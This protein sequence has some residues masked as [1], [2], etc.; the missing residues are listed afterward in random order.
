M[1]SVILVE[2]HSIVSVGVQTI[3]DR[4][5]NFS[6]KEIFTTGQ[7]GLKQI[8]LLEPDIAI[9]DLNLPDLSGESIIKDLFLNKA[10]TKI[11]VLSWQKFLPQVN[12]LLSLGVS[13]YILKDNSANEI[14][15]AL[16]NVR[17][18]QKYLSP[19]LNE[20]LLQMGEP[21]TEKQLDLFQ[22]AL[23]ERELEIAKLLCA[24]DA[25]QKISIKLGISDSTVRAHT[26]NI[27][28]KLKLKK[29]SEIAKYRPHFF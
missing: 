17:L 22:N 16:E 9:I 5:K 8:K 7:E 28:K 29:V 27:L 18:G 3:I 12:H 25:S 14:L 19:E 2:D 26:K 4:S 1:L 10:K 11:I 24:G 21:G 13:A 20:V 15:L 23:T 6:L